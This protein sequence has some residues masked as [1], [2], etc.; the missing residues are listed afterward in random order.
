VALQIKKIMDSRLLS[1]LFLVMILA[2][3]VALPHAAVHA[4]AASPHEM[5][6]LQAEA[7]RLKRVLAEQ[8]QEK[9]QLE[10]SSPKVANAPDA[11]V[12]A[13]PSS[14]LPLAAAPPPVPPQV[15]APPP[16]PPQVA[17]VAKQ[18]NLAGAAR[19]SHSV[20]SV[21]QVVQE[22]GN[23]DVN[24]PAKLQG[25]VDVAHVGA[26][27]P[28]VETPAME[29]R[30]LRQREHQNAAASN[31]M[32]SKEYEKA[33]RKDDHNTRDMI[34]TGVWC[35]VGVLGSAVV[36]ALVYHACVTK[37]SAPQRRVYQ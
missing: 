3:S 37:K 27:V 25:G 5:Q 8:K 33:S 35:A 22:Q 24:T 28:K 1:H 26:K 14:D 30:I 11:S 31:N 6:R 17:A 18:N 36:G 29:Q 10:I 16:V 23:D 34:M 21:D 2:C 9:F 32:L 15:A 20:P 7:A 4:A 13:P 19:A 12:V